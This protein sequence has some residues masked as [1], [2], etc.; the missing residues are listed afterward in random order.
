MAP[1]ILCAQTKLTMN[2]NTTPADNSTWAAIARP[3]LVGFCAQDIRILKVAIR[4]MQKPNTNIEKMNNRPW[5]LLRLNIREW[6]MALI[7]KSAI[8]T[9]QTG[10][11][12]FRFGIPPGMAF[13]GL[14]L[15]GIDVA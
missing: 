1:I 13:G 8:S 14:T 2:S 15:G 7:A 9:P 12:V 3:E 10:M 11:S 4:D 5:D 6:M